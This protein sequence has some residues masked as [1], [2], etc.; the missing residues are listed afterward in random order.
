[1]VDETIKLPKHI[2]MLEVMS[3]LDF[4][5]GKLENFVKEVVGGEISKQTPEELVGTLPE[6][7]VITTDLARV[8][9]ERVAQSIA[10]LREVLF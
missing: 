1:M 3:S 4:E 5:V 8:M 10:E 6:S 9:I 2:T 7:L